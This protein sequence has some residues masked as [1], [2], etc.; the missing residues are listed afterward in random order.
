MLPT[1]HSW[2]MSEALPNAHL[3][4]YPDSGHGAGFQYADLHSRHILAF[5]EE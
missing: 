4:I 3:H 1:Q 2:R 5:L